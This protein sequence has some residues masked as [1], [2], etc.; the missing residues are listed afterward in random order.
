MLP[1]LPS[2]DVFMRGGG[3]AFFGILGAFFSAGF[4]LVNQYLRQPG[5]LLVFWS[6]VLT[7]LALLPLM[8]HLALPTDPAFYIAVSLTVVFTV[9]GD[10]RTFNASAVHGAGVVS[11]LMPLTVWGSF[12][13]WFLFDPL[14]LGR[15]A[16]NPQTA[17]GICAA[18]LGC[19]FFAMRLNR[20]P[21]HR[22]VFIELLPALLAY[23]AT[24]VLNKYAMNHGPL[25]GAVFAYMFVQSSLA[26]VLTGFYA[27]WRLRTPTAPRITPELAARGFSPASALAVASVM[28][29]AVWIAHMVYKNSAM[30]YA[31]NP[32]YIAALGLTAPVFIS[33]YYRLTNHREE[34][35]VISGYGVVICALAL[36]VFTI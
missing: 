22:E 34:A 12:L 15:Y 21:V 1:D 19:V 30:A 2:F 13:V 11:R 32:A 28:M 20:S 17:L 3:W 16:Q 5:H 23:T 18:L 7:A 33:L 24:T 36:V 14:L 8:S 6:R 4:Y 27:L 35:D 26:A 31:A 9:L 25:I 10:I 29:S